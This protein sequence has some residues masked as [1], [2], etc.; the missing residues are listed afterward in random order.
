MD[1]EAEVGFVEPHAQR[2][3]GHQRLDP[4]GQQIRLE[5][6]A[7][8]G[9]GGPGVRGDVVALLT[10][11]RRDVMRLSDGEG[12]DDPRSRQRID[13]CCKPS[14]ALCRIAGVD[15]R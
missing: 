8:G 7:F 14:R 5:L 11:Q 1:D 6:F 4:V 15:H 9:F 12:V 13:V 2:R 10:Q 3:R